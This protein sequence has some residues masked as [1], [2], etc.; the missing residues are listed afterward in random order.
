MSLQDFNEAQFRIRI[1]K[2]LARVKTLLENSRNPQYATE[3]PH[4]YDDKYLLADTATNGA[5]R[6]HL[7]TLEQLGLTGAQLGQLKEWSS[8]RSVTLRFTSEEKC[9]FLRKTVREVQSDTKS[10][11]VAMN[12]VLVLCS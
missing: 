3:V 9:T 6:A 11:S 1:D 4:K 5:I 8:T 12:Y 7:V 10:V 2:A